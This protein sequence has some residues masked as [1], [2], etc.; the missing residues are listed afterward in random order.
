MESKFVGNRNRICSYDPLNSGLGVFGH[1]LISSDLRILSDSGQ[2][3][4]YRFGR[5]DFIDVVGGGLGSSSTETGRPFP[6]RRRIN[7]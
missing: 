3:L 6:R 1:S 4:S 7:L 5:E 2:Q